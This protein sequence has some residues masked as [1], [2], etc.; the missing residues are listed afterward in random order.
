MLFVATVV[1]LDRADGADGTFVAEDEIGSLVFDE[2]ISLGAALAADFVAEERAERDVRDNIKAFA[3]DF[4]QDLETVFLGA[5]HELLFRTV[6][7][8]IDGFAV[9][10]LIDYA[11]ENRDNQKD[12][13]SND[14][15]SDKK[16]V[17]TS[18]V[19]QMID[20]VKMRAMK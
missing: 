2:A 18:I 1:D 3:E 9:V 20:F 8:T 5:S 19:S 17:H 12:E 10:A 7:E 6:M 15:S 13:E 16:C 11:N 4:V 14:G